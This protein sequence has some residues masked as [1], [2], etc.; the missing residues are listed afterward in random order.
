MKRVN[1]YAG[2]VRTTAPILFVLM[3]LML[4]T[5]PAA[6]KSDLVSRLTF[7][8]INPA[9]AGKLH[10][11]WLPS[12]TGVLFYLHSILGFQMLVYR[13]KWIKPKRV[14]E[15]VVFVLGALVIA[16]FLWLFYA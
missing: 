13:V 4:M 14:W 6:F 12:L 9:N 2:I 11:V 8:L 7:G 10:A 16:Q 3:W 1:L 5:G 15:V